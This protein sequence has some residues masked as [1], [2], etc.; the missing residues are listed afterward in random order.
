MRKTGRLPFTGHFRG[1][2]ILILAMLPVPLACAGGDGPAG[3]VESVIVRLEISPTSAHLDAIGAEVR[4]EVV[5]REASGRAVPGVAPRWASSDPEVAAI[6]SSTGSATSGANGRTTISATLG[7]LNSSATLV[8]A[9]EL[10]SVL[11]AP[12]DLIVHSH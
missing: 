11:V 7:A 10:T 1:G 2:R 3:P 8:V 6:G 9:Q 5:A 12:N 4:F